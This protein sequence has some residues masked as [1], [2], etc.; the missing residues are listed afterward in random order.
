MIFLLRDAFVITI[1]NALTAIFA[2]FVVFSYIG[3]LAHVTSQEVK[4]VVSSGAGLV[5]IVFPF[6]V[7]QLPGGNFW[8][9]IFFIMMILLGID[10]QV[11]QFY[12]IFYT[13]I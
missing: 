6:A 3:Y 2:G 11:I 12:F 5:F 8:S 7:T 1:S 10:S 13:L 9:I 4:D